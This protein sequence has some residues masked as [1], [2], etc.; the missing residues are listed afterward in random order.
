MNSGTKKTYFVIISLLP[1]LL[2]TAGLYSEQVVRKLGWLSAK[3]LEENNLVLGINTQTEI[4]GLPV[5]LKIPNINVDA[6]I[7]NVGINPEGEME[8][9]LNTANV[10][11]FDLGPLPGENGSAV[12]AG[13]FNTADGKDGVFAH[14]NRLKSGDKVFVENNTGKVSTFI[15]R[16]N[17]SFDPDSANDFFTKSDGIHLNLVTCNGIWDKSKKSYTKR[18]VVFTDLLN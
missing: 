2:V 17:G 14:L 15:V 4:M 13:H 18:L 7:E 3:H 6:N 8:V 5:N 12:I 16:G 9:P 1:L 11:W 10:G